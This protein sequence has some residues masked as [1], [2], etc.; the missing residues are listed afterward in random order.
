[1]SSLSER[2][3][4]RYSDDYLDS[5]TRRAFLVGL[6]VNVFYLVVF[7]LLLALSLDGTNATIERENVTAIGYFL[8][9]LGGVLIGGGSVY[10]FRTSERAREPSQRFDYRTVTILG[11]FGFY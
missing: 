1:M 2:W 8:V 4:G 10:R 11:F 6:G 3:F 9:I 5:T 7:V